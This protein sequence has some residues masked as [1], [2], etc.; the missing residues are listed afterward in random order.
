M[1]RIVASILLLGLFAADASAHAVGVDWTLRQGK[2]EVEVFYD[3]DSAVQRA[4]VELVNA[5]DEVVE[6]A[7]TNK[8]G[9]CVLRRPAAGKY[10]VRVDAGAGH[11]AKKKIDVPASTDPAPSEVSVSPARADFTRFPWE[12]VLIG[13]VGIGAMGGAFLLGSMIRRSKSPR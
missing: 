12:K 11:R 4:K 13:F 3:D 5:M 1:Q 8:Q 10:E 7:V 6:S 2:I 9:R